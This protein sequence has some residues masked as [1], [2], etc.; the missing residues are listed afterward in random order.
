[1]HLEGHQEV[2]LGQNQEPKSCLLSVL[3]SWRHLALKT[4][5]GTGPLGLRWDCPQAG[6][7]VHGE[8]RS[9][10]PP[11]TPSSA[12][13]SF[14]FRTEGGAVKGNPEAAFPA[15]AAETKPSLAPA[16]PPVPPVTTATASSL[17]GPT[18]SL[19][20]VPSTPTLLAWK[21]LA[22]TIPQMPQIPASVPHLP[23]SPLA[24]T[25]LENA[26]PQVKPGFLQFQE[27]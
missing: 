7:Q 4:R 24:T 25:S 23:T 27:K 20:A 1:M 12:S 9:P 6:R 17:E 21:Q 15:S 10:P 8:G 14:H 11:E 18:P 19:A 22:S 2:S 3:P 13:H 26:K 5:W 16:S